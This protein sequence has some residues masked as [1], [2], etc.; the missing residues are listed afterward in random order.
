MRPG[1]E[2]LQFLSISRASL[3]EVEYFIHFMNRT[4]LMTPE[5]HQ[6]LREQRKATAQRLHGFIKYV[7]SKVNSDGTKSDAVYESP[8]EYATDVEE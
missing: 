7:R 3:A 6:K 2:F 4:G 1:V 8:E 5:Q